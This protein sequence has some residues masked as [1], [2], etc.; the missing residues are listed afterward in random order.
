MSRWP[1]G[2]LWERPACSQLLLVLVLVLVLGVVEVLLLLLLP[3]L[4]LRLRLRFM[5]SSGTTNQ[6]VTIAK[7]LGARLQRTRPP[8][9]EN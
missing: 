5:L 3:L 1:S 4:Q 2:C 6:I 7:S 9:M 8:P